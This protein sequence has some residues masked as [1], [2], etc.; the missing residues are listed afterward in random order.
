VLDVLRSA[1]PDLVVEGDERKPFGDATV[2]DLIGE[3]S[4]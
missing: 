1:D 3:Q 2:S 4:T